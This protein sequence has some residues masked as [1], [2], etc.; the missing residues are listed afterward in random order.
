MKF[1]HHYSVTLFRI[2]KEDE[3]GEI[4]NIPGIYLVYDIA[5]ND[6]RTLLYIGESSN[7]FDRLNGNHESKLSGRLVNL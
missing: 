1:V 5:A 4:P 2:Y 6:E 7:I 3:I